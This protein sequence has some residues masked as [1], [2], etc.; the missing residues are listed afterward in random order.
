MHSV[1][2][3]NKDARLVLSSVFLPAI[4]ASSEQQEILQLTTK[5]FHVYYRL[6]MLQ[7]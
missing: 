1:E 7:T 5:F 3:H 2:V 6:E 4:L